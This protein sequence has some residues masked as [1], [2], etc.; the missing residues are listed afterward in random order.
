MSDT[1]TPTASSQEETFD[2]TPEGWAQRWTKEMKAAREWH[3]DWKKKGAE[4]VE[5]YLDRRKGNLPEGIDTRWNFYTA[6]IQTQEAMLYGKPPQVDV[7][8]RYADANDS[9]ARVAGEVFE[10]MLNA[11][12]EREGD[13]FA[14]ALGLCLKDRLNPG[15]GI[16]RF[17]YVA[18]F[19]EEETP[20]KEAM[21]DAEGN[22]LAP[23]VPS[24]Q[25]KSYEDVETDY[26][27]WRD[28]LWGPARTWHEVPW[29][30][31]RAQLSMEEKKKRFGEEVAKE[32]P[33]SNVSMVSDNDSDAAKKNP[34][35]RTDVWEVWDKE[36]ECVW[37][38]V[39][40]YKRVLTPLEL[41]EEANENGS[42]NDTLGLEGFFPCQ[43]PMLANLTTSDFL[44]R[45]DFTLSQDLYDEIDRVSS[46]I[47][48]LERAIGVKGL[49]NK[50]AGDGVQR[51][52][53]ETQDGTL[54]PVE[55]WE[56][57]SEKGGIRGAVD[58]FPL[59]MVVNA[60][61]KLR[62]YRG[63]LIQSLFQLTGMSDIMR[64]QA[65]DVAATATEQS[66][67][68]RFASVRMQAL[69]DEFARFASDGQ[70]IRAEII[71]KHF[72]PE[73]ILERSNIQRSFDG[74]Q[75]QLLQQA[76]QLLKD[77]HNCYRI[78]VKPE[79][80]S[81]TD[82]AAMKAEGME[83]LG[84]LT[85]FVQSAA[86]LAQ[87]LPGSLPFLL[88][89]LQ[90]TMSRLRGASTIEGVIDQAITH[91]EQAAAAQAAAP[92]QPPPPDPKLVA[93]Q[94]KAQL[95]G[96]REQQ[97]LQADLVRMNAEVQAENQKQQNQTEWNVKEDVARQS[98]KQ[99]LGAS[100]VPAPTPTPGVP[101]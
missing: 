83:V 69:Q 27:H 72:E 52:L 39:E 42:L 74:E 9:A 51:L 77:E 78:E 32:L 93:A 64:G 80:I 46:R 10:R 63:E 99:G 87:Q 98:I 71:S 59:D 12:I 50:S 28:V 75:P 55:N 91:A 20:G 41:K 56:A 86:P 85:G 68:A 7:R 18:D 97:K 53:R 25:K 76:V 79:A 15:A 40:G 4:I 19:D 90:W 2:D 44:P 58:W 35:A 38:W 47:T 100:G 48:G 61:D 49:Y 23:A 34:W 82:F 70:R 24:V 54:I 92:Q 21:V 60:L 101:Q 29:V 1:T 67:K 31:F 11:D 8:P 81:L 26:V 43:R 33:T 3:E 94:Q 57:F 88:K 30:A 62:E 36:K 13:G 96:Q 65:S 73:T 6:N 17:R 66:I 84:G 14:T 37:F 16:M 89:M 5:R 45:A 95:D 22:E